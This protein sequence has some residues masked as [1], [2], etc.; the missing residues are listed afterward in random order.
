[1]EVPTNLENIYFIKRKEMDT[2]ERVH[3]IPK[4]N[5]HAINHGFPSTADN[6][7]LAFSAIVL[8]ENLLEH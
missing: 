2:L 6:L 8:V 4:S 1:M 5:S 7:S 3:G